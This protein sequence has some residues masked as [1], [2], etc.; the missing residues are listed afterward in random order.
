MRVP[1]TFLLLAW[2]GGLP[3]LAGAETWVEMRTPHFTVVSNAG[4]GTA[5]KTAGEFEQVRAA[6]GRIWPWAKLAQ[7]RPIVV[8][9]FK[10]DATLKLW[11]PAYYEVKGGIDLVSVTAGG[12]DREYLL[13]RT[14][15][16]PRDVDVTPN[17]NLYRAY[18][19]LILSSSFERRLPLWLSNGLSDVLGNVS[20]RENDISLGRPVPWQ[21]EYFNQNGRLPLAAILDA[22]ADSPLVTHEDQRHTFDA[23]CY[24]LAHYLLFGDHGAHSAALARFQQLWLSG[25]SQ[26]EAM[27]EAFG[28]L[29]ALEQALT[30][31]ATRPILSYARF[32]G[33]A[34]IAAQKPEQRILSSAEVPGLQAAVLVALG[35][36]VEAQAAIRLARTAD[37]RSPLSYDAEG[38]LADHDKDR[39]RAAAAYAKA[40]ELG[41][42]SAYSHYR[43]AQLAWKPDADAAEL[44]ALQLRLQRVIELNEA[45]AD[46]HSFLAEVLVQ[47][48]DG[49]AALASAQRAVALEPGGAYHRVALARALAKVG[50]ADE[51]RKS[52]EL[53]LRLAQGDSERSNAERFLLYLDET[54]RY[55][56]ERT[57]R[58]ALEKKTSACQGGDAAACAEILPDFERSC[59]QNDAGACRYLAW[60]YGGH[61]GLAKDAAQAAGYVDRACAAGDKPSC[62][63]QAWSLARGE[64]RARNEP[65]GMAALDALCNGGFLP[66]CT[67]L[68]MIQAAKPGA[69]PRARAKALLARACAGGEADACSIAKGLR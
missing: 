67:R 9:A 31:Y 35:R 43:A 37:A 23:Q 40:V 58:E 63:D 2:V 13:L 33:E 17:Y 12:A 29:G 32:A 3:V 64:G 69:L 44:S 4:E 30:S 28:D 41:S 6:Y 46:A 36:P 54:S 47:E 52:A 55:A 39:T 51:A 24:V 68:A 62:L 1:G 22:R 34:R 8:L 56:R 5:R 50:R 16:R 14:D 15:A 49:P 66:A 38:L 10:N 26:D 65:R 53:G 61:G 7:A 11:A 18:L 27:A 21:L 60:L 25:R 20:V 45:Y 57:Q 19:S 59:G 42:T 48:G